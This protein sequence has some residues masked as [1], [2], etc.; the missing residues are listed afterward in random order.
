MS[1]VAK[2]PVE[3]KSGVEITIAGQ[4]ITVK[5]SKGTLNRTFNDAVEVV[6]EENQLKV[7]PREGFADGWAQAGTAR[8]LLNAMV[9]GVSEGFEKK[10]QLIGVGYRAQAQ[11]AK[12][13]LT[14]G[15]S[16]PVVYEMPQ[17]ITV[18]T[19]SQT[20]VV[21]KGADKQLVG[22]VAANIRGYRP[23]EPYKGKGVRYADEVVRRKEAK[24]K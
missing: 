8:A 22:Q 17:G 19:P 2:A 21:V 1:R 16:H 14:L 4:D 18:E 11:G 10:L 13:N 6:Q 3:I 15:F 9:I 23:P 7:A 24:K 20:E 12:L 5:G